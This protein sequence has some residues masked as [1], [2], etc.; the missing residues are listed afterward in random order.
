MS[1]AIALFILAGVFGI[2]LLWLLIDAACRRYSA[3]REKRDMRIRDAQLKRYCITP[4]FG[5]KERHR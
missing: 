5:T 4:M 1:G 2:G 3:W